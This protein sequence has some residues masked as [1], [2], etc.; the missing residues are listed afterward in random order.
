MQAIWNDVVVA[1]SSQT[2]DMKGYTYF[3]R[4]AVRMDLLT[5]V[6]RA[7]SDLQCPHGVQF[8]DLAHAGKDRKSVV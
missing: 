2:R 7:G 6:P 3:P 8:Y 5:S 1:E 4:A